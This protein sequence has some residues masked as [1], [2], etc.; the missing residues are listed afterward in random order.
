MSTTRPILDLSPKAIARRNSSNHRCCCSHRRVAPQ[1]PRAQPKP[2]A[3]L[4]PLVKVLYEKLNDK[5]RQSVCF[6]WEHNDSKLGLLRTR[7]A[8]N[9]HI[10]KPNLNS[11]F[12]TAEQRD[13]VRKIFEASWMP[14]GYR[15]STSSLKMT[16]VALR[17]TKNIAI[18][19]KPGDGN[20]E[21]VLTGRHMTLRC[22]GN[23]AES[24]AFRRSDFLWSRTYR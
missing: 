15:S 3:H 1:Q 6:D 16:A 22:D 19:G 10:T 7:V 18:F 13:L 20:F 4:N 21:F 11:E 9:W 23:S 2:R 24:V 5:Q 17:R 12:F 14:T 8:N